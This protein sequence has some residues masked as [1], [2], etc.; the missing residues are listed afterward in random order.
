MKKKQMV[1]ILL[2][3]G[4]LISSMSVS[5]S[6]LNEK[7]S[8]Y[9]ISA[10][11]EQN[12][13]DIHNENVAI[14]PLS[15]GEWIQ[16]ADGRWRYRHSDGSYTVNGW[17][18]INGSWYYFDASG[19]MMTGW[20]QVN[21]NWYYLSSSGAMVT[22]WQFI[23]YPGINNNQPYY[24]YFNSSGAFVT[25]SDV[26]GC[27]HGYSTFKDY[28]YQVNLKSM[29]YYTSCSSSQNS[30]IAV[31]VNAWNRTGLLSMSQVNFSNIY[32]STLIFSG[33]VFQNPNTL[34]STEFCVNYSWGSNTNGNWTKARVFVD[35]D[36]GTI[37]SGTIAHEIGHALGLA[38]KISNQSSIMCQTRNGRKV[39]TPQAMDIE[40]VNHIY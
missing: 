14:N 19:W 25:D 27:G 26:I 9:G 1:G 24:N 37:N 35:T 22:G 12:L 18:Y 23:S 29:K 17:E 38:H 32:D 39:S 16:A 31:G 15:D 21:G 11:M 3:V 2:I 30:A 36:Q 5:A 7:D 6:Q 33:T 10:N 28:K 13:E 34:A 20:I 4:C 8:D 40:A